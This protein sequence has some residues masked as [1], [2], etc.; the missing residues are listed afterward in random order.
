MSDVVDHRGDFRTTSCI[1]FMSIIGGFVVFR[2]AAR[3]KMHRGNFV[4]NKGCVIATITSDADEYAKILYNRMFEMGLRV[5]LDVRNEKIN[6]KVREHSLA[7]VPVMFV[8][9]N[10]EAEEN[11]VAIRTLGEKSQSIKPHDE[12]IESLA[13]S[14]KAPY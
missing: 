11:S 4:A 8:V 10:R 3:T 1:D 7:K 12:A 9:G 6:Y 5:E 14:C 2:M 13:L